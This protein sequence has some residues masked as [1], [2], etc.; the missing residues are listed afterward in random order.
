[1]GQLAAEI[2]R[3]AEGGRS[4]IDGDPLLSVRSLPSAFDPVEAPDGPRPDRMRGPGHLQV[5][6]AGAGID[7]MRSVRSDVSSYG[8]LVKDWRPYHPQRESIDDVIEACSSEKGFHPDLSGVDELGERLVDARLH[9][10][11][12]TLIV[13]PWAPALAGQADELAAFDKEQ[14]PSAPMFVPWSH[15]D[16][17]TRE[18]RDQLVHRLAEVMP[19]AHRQGLVSRMD[20]G[21]LA[22]FQRAISWDLG[23]AWDHVVQTGEPGRTVSGEQP[24]EP[25]IIEVP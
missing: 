16:A 5:V 18:N 8:P 21:S 2:V 4:L 3:I 23:S 7:D 14:G 1:V 10:E 12:V 22:E 20:L 9:N 25:P 19:G 13:D 17:E 15:D 11:V 24:P 6:I